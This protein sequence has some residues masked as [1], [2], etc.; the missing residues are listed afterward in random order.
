MDR[1][2]D[3]PLAATG[4]AHDQDRERCGGGGRDLVEQT[5]V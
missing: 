5:A 2:T 3:V 1:P 4:L